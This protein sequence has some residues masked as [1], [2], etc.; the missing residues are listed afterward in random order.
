MKQSLRHGAFSA[1]FRLIAATDAW[2]WLAPV[3]R[4]AGVI[5]TL[6]HVRPWRA[7]PFAPNRL[8]EITPGFLDRVLSVVRETGFEIVP[9]DDVPERLRAP[10]ERRP[11]AVLTFDDGYRDNLEHALPVLRRHDAPWTL[12]IT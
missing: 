12:F 4:G 9:L 7:R 5:L 10:D 1:G 8:L 2:R 11:F 6:H 3:A